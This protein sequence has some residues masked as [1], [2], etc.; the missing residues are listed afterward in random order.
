MQTGTHMAGPV[1]EHPNVRWNRIG[2]VSLRS[3]IETKR[4]RRDRKK[5]RAVRRRKWFSRGNGSGVTNGRLSAC[6]G[7]GPPRP[8]RENLLRVR[9]FPA[10]QFQEKATTPFALNHRLSTGNAPQDQTLH[11]VCRSIYI[12]IRICN[13]IQCNSI[14]R[15]TKTNMYVRPKSSR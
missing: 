8:Y 14:T 5:S 9:S 12:D 15:R 1:L 6:G 4:F 2:I 3:L 10:V 7:R 11:P 13:H